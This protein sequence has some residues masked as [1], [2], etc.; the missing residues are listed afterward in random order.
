MVTRTMRA[1]EWAL[2]GLLALVWGGTFYFVE[3]MLEAMDPVSAVL[4]RVAPAAAAL[5]ILVYATGLR[6]PGDFASWRA[7]F[8][9][10]LLNNVVPFSL[11]A[12]AQVHIES[13]LASILNA[14]TPLFTVLLAHWLTRDEPMSVNRALGV[15][16]GLAGVA[17]LIGPG[18]LNELG[19]DIL[20]QAAVLA[21]AVCYGLA[22]VH[23]RRLSAL[24]T[25][26]AAAGML[27]ASTAMAFP[28]AWMFGD[29]SAISFAPGTLGA[30]LGQSLLSTALAYLIYFRVL[31][32]A[33]AT[34]LLLVIF[35]I[36][37]IA[38]GLGVAFLG[39]RPSALSLAGMAVIFL[40]L[41]LVDG[42]VFRLSRR[43]PQ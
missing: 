15:L 31:A 7:L 18:A 39:E 23:G 12:W 22:E 19:L 3:I 6:L 10:G 28:L 21:A 1:T 41:I 35:L 24:P 26:V 14:T 20:A 42:R 17:L 38:L 13:G 4:L 34:N 29:L 9:M 5:T 16:A 40:G 8:I 33:G 43:V 11:I 25:T 30:I 37:P 32:T 36:P 2:V 27:I